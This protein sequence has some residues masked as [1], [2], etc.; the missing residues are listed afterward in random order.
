MFGVSVVSNMESVSVPS[1]TPE[2]WPRVHEVSVSLRCWFAAAI[3]ACPPAMWLRSR[4]RRLI[5]EGRVGRGE[6]VGCGYDLRESPG[7]CPECGAIRRDARRITRQCS[8][9]PRRQPAQ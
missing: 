5:V 2:K 6:C 9:P 3:S 4:R 1:A 7:R 8:G